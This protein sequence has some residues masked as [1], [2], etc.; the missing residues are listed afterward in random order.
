MI[1]ER[2]QQAID[3]LTRI[4]TQ[5]LRLNSPSTEVQQKAEHLGLLLDSMVR[6]MNG[7][8]ALTI[9]AITRVEFIINSVQEAVDIQIASNSTYNSDIPLSISFTT[10]PL[11]YTSDPSDS[12]SDNNA[13]IGNIAHGISS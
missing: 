11:E 4:H 12:D 1:K 7:G 13:L 6:N 3:S 8:V 9:N 2:T 5:F 10:R